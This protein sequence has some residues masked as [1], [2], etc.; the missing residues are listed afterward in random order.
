MRSWSMRQGL[1]SFSFHVS[2]SVLTFSQLPRT[3][4]FHAILMNMV[5][6]AGTLYKA[7]GEST[8]KR[9]QVLVMLPSQPFR[10]TNA[11]SVPGVFL[12][13][14][15]SGNFTEVLPNFRRPSVLMHKHFSNFAGRASV[16]RAGGIPRREAA[17]RR[18][19]FGDR[20]ARM[21]RSDPSASSEILPVG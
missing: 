15:L 3:H 12:T 8:S 1:K 17:E 14:V 6:S 13:C 4:Y 16:V 7:Q 21:R 19:R 11:S 18:N 2:R 5:C 20:H 10:A 9:S